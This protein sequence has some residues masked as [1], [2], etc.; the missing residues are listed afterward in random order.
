MSAA[1]GSARM[2]RS[3]CV[4]CGEWG[5]G[6]RLI[7]EDVLAEGTSKPGQGDT[8]EMQLS[9]AAGAVDIV[10]DDP[11]LITDAGLVPVVAL[12]EQIGLPGLVAGHVAIPREAYRDGAS[13][14]A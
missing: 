13:P 12:A 1:F 10:F 4:S 14:A 3:V 5:R 2:H 6:C 11:N 7:W 9:H 8:R